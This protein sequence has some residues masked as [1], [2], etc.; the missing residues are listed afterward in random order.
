[1]NSYLSVGLVGLAAIAVASAAFFNQADHT[2]PYAGQESRKISSLSP[3]DI[4]ELKKG[5]GW[6]LAKAAELN[7]L[8]G[9]AHLLEMKDEIPLSAVQIA[10]IEE[11]RDEMRVEAKTQGQ[12]LIDLERALDQGF[13]ERE[14]S[15]ESLEAALDELGR[16]RA[17]L[18]YAHLA[19]HLQTPDI[20]SDE[21]VDQY[22]RLRGYATNA[23]PC[24]NV[25]SGHNAAMWRKHNGCE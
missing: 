23:D 4:A 13:K 19:A 10:R 20:L 6:G 2:S 1:M 18:R 15:P 21:Q 24:A 8:P 9:P 16:V 14:F 7:G 12:I 5:S 17:K 3:D 11:V 25:P 22:N